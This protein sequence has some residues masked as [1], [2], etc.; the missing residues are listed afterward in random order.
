MVSTEV[1]TEK[2]NKT[3]PG[4]QLYKSHRVTYYRTPDLFILSNKNLLPS[5][6]PWQL[7]TTTGIRQI[8]TIVTDSYRCQKSRSTAGLKQ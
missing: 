7:Q 5:K 2:G 3:G 8:I 6:L 1:H 4:N